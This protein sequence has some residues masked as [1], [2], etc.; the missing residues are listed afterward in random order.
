MN[1]LENGGDVDL[2]ERETIQDEARF[3]LHEM[4]NR[5]DEQCVQLG[6]MSVVGIG[7]MREVFLKL[8]QEGLI[9]FV[10]RPIPWPAWCVK[11]TKRGA[12]RAEQLFS[13][14]VR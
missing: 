4:Y 1:N 6:S 13:V 11:L 2:R 3:F 8:E 9:E 7:K 10:R 14:R 5:R 12:K